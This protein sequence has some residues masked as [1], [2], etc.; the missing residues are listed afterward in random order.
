MASSH[1]VFRFLL[2]GLGEGPQST[3]PS[4]GEG[5]YNEAYRG[6]G[7]YNEAYRGKVA[8]LIALNGN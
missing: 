7:G 3:A 8:V 2:S 4:R 6:E 1:M 5:G